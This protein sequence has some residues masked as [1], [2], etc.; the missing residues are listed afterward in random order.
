MRFLFDLCDHNKDGYI[1]FDEFESLYRIL[2]LK[3]G[4][5]ILAFK[6]LDVNKDGKLSK[7]EMYDAIANYFSDSNAT[8]AFNLFGQF[9]TL[10]DDYVQKLIAV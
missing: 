5:I 6:E 7:L 9:E 2:G 8:R 4:N 1:D 3:R 10:S